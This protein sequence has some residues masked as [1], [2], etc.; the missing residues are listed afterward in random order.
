MGTF[1]FLFFPQIFTRPNSSPVGVL[2][3]RCYFTLPYTP[4]HMLSFLKSLNQNLEKHVFFFFGEVV[5]CIYSDNEGKKPEAAAAERCC[6]FT[7]SEI[8]QQRQCGALKL[9][10]CT[11]CLLW[12]VRTHLRDSHFGTHGDLLLIKSRF[13]TNNVVLCSC[14]PFQRTCQWTF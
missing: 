1:R 7:A 13:L 9:T 5:S 14:R 8:W 10:A 4:P 2:Y 12:D 11:L 3:C 6:G